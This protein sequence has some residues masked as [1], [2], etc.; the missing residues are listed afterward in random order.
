MAI[1]SWRSETLK[2]LVKTTKCVNHF[3]QQSQC[4][5]NDLFKRLSVALPGLFSGR[6]AHAT[7][8]DQVLLPAVKLANTMRMS[9]SEYVV[10]IQDSLLTKFKPVTIDTL[11]MRKMVDSKSEKHLKPDS[12][13]VADND[14]VIGKVIICLEP[15]LYRVTKG[16]ETTL[17]QETI[18]VELYHPLAKRVKTSA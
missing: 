12:P 14:G 1:A 5:N 13:I 16:K 7:F 4:L 9:T 10:S 11:R 15:G 6:Q 3:H 18:L 17:Q 8:Y 2:A